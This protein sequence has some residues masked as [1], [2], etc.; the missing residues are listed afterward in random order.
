MG[1]YRTEDL[2]DLWLAV[3]VVMCQPASIA[4]TLM[5]YSPTDVPGGPGDV[6]CSGRI[7]APGPPS[8]VILY[9]ATN[10]QKAF[11]SNR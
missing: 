6:V 5:E 3:G 2:Q 10:L 9:K 4:T 8:E 1:V 7:S 11:N